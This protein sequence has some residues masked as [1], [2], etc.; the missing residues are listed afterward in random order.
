MPCPVVSLVKVALL[1]CTMFSP[2][3]WYVCPARPMMLAGRHD[4]GRA[5]SKVQ[6]NFS[7]TALLG[8]SRR[9][10]VRS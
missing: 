1:V 3:C 8:V 10:I 7:Q 4:R 6:N 9:R 5:A 2:G